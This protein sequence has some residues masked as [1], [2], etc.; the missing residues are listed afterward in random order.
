VAWNTICQLDTGN[1]AL[2]NEYTG[3]ALSHRAKINNSRSSGP[4]FVTISPPAPDQRNQQLHE[5]EI[6]YEVLCPDSRH[7][8]LKNFNPAYTKLRDYI[9]PVFVPYGKAST[10][11]TPS[12]SYQF[13]CQHGSEECLGN[14]IHACA[15]KYV[16]DEEELISYIGCMINNN[17][18][19]ESIAK[20]CATELGIDIAPI[21]N[22]WNSKEGKLLLKKYGDMTHALRPEVSFIPTITIDKSQRGQPEILKNFF[23][24]MCT[25]VLAEERPAICDN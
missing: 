10:V 6:Y 1:P 4:E 13:D 15:I 9:K 21:S 8:I 11:L 2:S 14:T 25:Y 18:K 22:C 17:R 16:S 23:V 12:G 24:Y 19:S 7:F 5:V 3:D 20:K